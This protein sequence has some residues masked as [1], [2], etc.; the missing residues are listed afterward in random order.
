[1]HYAAGGKTVQV[2]DEVDVGGMPGIVVFSIDT[3]EYG[4]DFTRITWEYLGQGVGVRTKRGG[5][6]HLQDNSELV[7]IS[8]REEG[9]R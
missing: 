7:L 5:L 8:R 1:V 4:P 3:D 2:G 6:V 9:G